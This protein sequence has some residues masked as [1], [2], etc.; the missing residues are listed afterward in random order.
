MD[1]ECLKGGRS[2]EDVPEVRLVHLVAHGATLI[3]L[4]DPARQID[5][6]SFTLKKNSSK[7]IPI[8]INIISL[9]FKLL[10]ITLSVNLENLN[11]ANL[12]GKALA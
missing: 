5:C 11:L 4:N 1:V 12:M 10:G 6:Y 8:F 2:E 9:L 3:A 7:L